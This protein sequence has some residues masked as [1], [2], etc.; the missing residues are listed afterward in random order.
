MNDHTPITGNYIRIISNN[1]GHQYTIDKVYR[2]T[3]VDEDDHTLRAMDEK[4]KE[5]GW[6]KWDET[7]PA[8]M[9]NWVW[10][11]QQL[12]DDV[13]CFLEAFSGL[14]HLRL[15]E[16]VV[17]ALLLDLPDLPEHILTVMR[18]HQAPSS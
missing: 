18:N 5:H 1:G 7:E 15:R 4:G 14:E 9:I 8:A 2:I 6:I 11:R 17:D 10:L 16:T 12:P 13:V 3:T